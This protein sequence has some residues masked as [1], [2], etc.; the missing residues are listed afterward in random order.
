MNSPE[1]P[2]LSVLLLTDNIP[3]P[4][5]PY[6]HVQQQGLF[7][8]QFELCVWLINIMTTHV[9]NLSFMSL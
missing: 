1:Y 9:I 2:G 6:I 7:Q 4:N 5:N 8:D 3:A